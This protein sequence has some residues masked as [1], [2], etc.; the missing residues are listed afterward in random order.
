MTVTSSIG[1]YGLIFL[2]SWI[3]LGNWILLN[4]LQAILLD[5]FDGDS[6]NPE[7]EVGNVEES[8]STLP[9]EEEPP[10]EDD[11]VA[12][13]SKGEERDSSKEDTMRGDE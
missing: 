7:Q 1:T 8:N 3:F 4:L 5:G 2:L 12:L 6:I 13:L 11:E 9:N 10:E